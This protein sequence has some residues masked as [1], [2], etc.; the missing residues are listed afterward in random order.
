MSCVEIL[1]RRW[2]LGLGAN[3]GDRRQNLHAA[4]RQIA[5]HPEVVLE[6]VAPLYETPPMGPPQPDYLN[7]AVRI[8]TNLRPRKLLEF[9]LQ[10]ERAMGRER[11]ERWGPRTIDID[12]LDW[13]GPAIAEDGLTVPHPGLRKRAFVW[14]PYL[15]VTWRT[16]LEAP[17][18]LER[19]PAIRARK[20]SQFSLV[21]SGVAPR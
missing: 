12:L 21:R 14:F 3:L 16:A 6:H 9:V 7:T 4:I 18:S 8:R 15:D 1:S 2:V 20:S 11:L 17:P 19:P 10:I 13:D 5:S